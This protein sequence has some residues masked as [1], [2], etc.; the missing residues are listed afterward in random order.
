MFIGGSP[1]STAGGIKTTTFAIILANAVASARN[2]GNIVFFKRR[3]SDYTIKLASAI[4]GIYLML[5]VGATLIVCA[6]ES[7]SFGTVLFEVVSALSTTGFSH[8][9]ID[10]YKTLTLIVYM[11]L[12]Y[13][14]R[15]GALAFVLAFA[16]RR[17]SDM[18]TRPKGNLL[19]G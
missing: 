13:I 3:I 18:L 14:G 8:G 9:P 17:E 6:L 5:T 4:F 12:M 16:E 2:R 11:V 15:V 1:G 7:V 19:I 10:G